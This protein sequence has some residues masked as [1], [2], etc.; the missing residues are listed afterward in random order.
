[1]SYLNGSNEIGEDNALTQNVWHH[2]VL[3]RSGGTTTLYKNGTS[4]GTY[5]DSL[6]YAGPQEGI[7][8]FGSNAGT[9]GLGASRGSY[10]TGRIGITRTYKGR[11]LTLAE[12][13]S[14]YNAGYTATTSAVAATV[15]LNPNDNLSWN[16]S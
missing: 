1:M 12:V 2:I 13:T 5:S 14:N 8:Y 9:D 6:N 7:V 16:S 11:A 4:V 3:T 10:V 15:D